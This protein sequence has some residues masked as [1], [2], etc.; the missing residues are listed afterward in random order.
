MELVP[1]KTWDGRRVM[2]AVCISCHS[3]C[4]IEPDDDYHRQV[5]PDFGESH[6][7]CEP[8]LTSLELTRGHTAFLVTEH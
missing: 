1:A 8:C 7:F 6:E 4:A 2:R 5:G 3:V